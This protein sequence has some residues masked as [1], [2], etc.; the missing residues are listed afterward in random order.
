MSKL[1]ITAEKSKNLTL[2]VDLTQSMILL[3]IEQLFCEVCLL[4]SIEHILIA[5]KY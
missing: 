3:R 2:H 1:Q 5:S 4:T